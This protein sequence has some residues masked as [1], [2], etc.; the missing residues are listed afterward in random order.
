[1]NSPIIM[2]TEGE[3][4]FV[5]LGERGY[6]ELLA[7]VMAYGCDTPDRTGVGRRKL[8]E[9]FL[10]F[11]LRKS[12]PAFTSRSTPP[13][14]AIIEFWKFLN[15]IPDL[16]TQLSKEGI[17]FWKGNTTREFLDQRGLHHLPEGHAGKSY[18]F[19]VRHFGG[20]YDDNFQPKGGI[21]Q[22]RKIY[23]TLA[24]DPFDSRLLLSM[25]NPEQEQDMA[26]PPCWWGHQFLT[27]IDK[28]GRNVLNL[29]VNSRSA[30]LVF[31]TPYNV[32]QYACYL[33]AMAETQDMIAGVL[34]CRLTDAHV[35]GRPEDLTRAPSQNNSASQ[36]LFVQE[37]LAREFSEERVTLDFKRPLNNLDD[38]LNLTFDDFDIGN[39]H[40]NLAPFETPRPTMAV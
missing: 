12:F 20:D 32:T 37:L 33:A 27:T 11:D 6:M 28:S 2:P 36:F 40:P 17:N 29:N 14:S 18:G 31:G 38:L 1:M 15:G 16:H 30:D 9:R 10:R 13:R 19:Q 25:W 4:K 21:D 8:F 22:L 39:Y 26:L 35:Y 24:K 23:D 34:S 7:D 3:E 5:Y